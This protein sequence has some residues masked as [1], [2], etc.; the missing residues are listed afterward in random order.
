MAGAV[1]RDADDM[2]K[3][4][5]ALNQYQ[6]NVTQICNKMQG[7]ISEADNYMR[8][9]GSRKALIKMSEVFDEIRSDA[10][11]GNGMSLK[12]KTSA[13]FVREASSALRR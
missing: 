8:D 6:E 10:S 2:D 4:A 7:L 12:L 3:F 11:F 1:I 9:E 13:R 5:E